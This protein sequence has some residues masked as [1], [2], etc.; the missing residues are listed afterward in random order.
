MSF[1]TS[2]HFPVMGSGP[3]FPMGRSESVFHGEGMASLQSWVFQRGQNLIPR[4]W[5]VNPHGVR[6]ESHG[7]SAVA[8]D[9]MCGSVTSVSAFLD[10][11]PGQF[12][13]VLSVNSSPRYL[14]AEGLIWLPALPFSD[15]CTEQCVSL[16]LLSAPL[17]TG[18]GQLEAEGETIVELN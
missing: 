13:P 9:H 11:I 17:R 16:A 5:S 12:W 7:K 10:G 15:S 3:S 2:Q 1:Y 8:L 18:R 4:G 14:A 6:P